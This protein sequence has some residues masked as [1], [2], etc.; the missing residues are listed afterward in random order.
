MLVVVEGLLSKPEVKHFRE[1]LEGAEWVDGRRSA[2]SVSAAVKQNVQ[3]EEDS[4]IAIALGEQILR[5]LGQN[6][7]FVSATLPEKIYPPKFNRYAGGGRYG[8][9]VDSAVMRIARAGVTLRADVSATLFLS[10]PEEYEGGVLTIE[11]AY[12][13]Q[14]IKLAAG[15]LVLYPAGSLH[16]V[17]PV[18]SGART[19]AFFWVQSMVGDLA[20]RALLY[21]LDQAIQGL[22]A[23]QGGGGGEEILRLTGV[24]NNLLRLWAAV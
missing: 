21:D 4:A 9:H 1:R 17:S 19:A 5:T 23:R 13:A 2:G 24:Y 7:T 6:P 14:E 3:L 20:Q 18:T 12:G 11:G 16:Q 15:D 10:E 22:R 8:A